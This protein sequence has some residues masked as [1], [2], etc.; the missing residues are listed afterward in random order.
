M[1]ISESRFQMRTTGTHFPEL[2]D[3]VGDILT[4][5]EDRFRKPPVPLP[6]DE[7]ESNMMDRRTCAVRHTSFGVL[8]EH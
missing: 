5:S 4:S 6:A 2:A 7:T 1:A 8:N 3:A